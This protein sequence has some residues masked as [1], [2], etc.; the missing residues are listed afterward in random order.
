MLKLATTV[1]SCGDLHF[2]HHKHFCRQFIFTYLRHISYITRTYG[3]TGVI[4]TGR[5]S[6][7]HFWRLDVRA[8]KKHARTSGPYVR[9]VYT[10]RTYGSS[11]PSFTLRLLVWKT[12]TVT[13]TLTFDLST[14][15]PCHLLGYPKVIP[16]TKFEHFGIIIFELCCRQ[17]NKHM[18]LNVL[19]TST[20]I[21]GMDN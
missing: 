17:T 7:R 3:W 18:A 11:A 12:L 8:S 1:S 2:A 9:A 20:N 10:A 13:L 15:K 5:T 16:Y 6:G 4:S 19:L 21:V 14:L